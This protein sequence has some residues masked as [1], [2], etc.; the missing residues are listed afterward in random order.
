[1]KIQNIRLSLEKKA[2]ILG[3]ATVTRKS[4]KTF[5]VFDF[6]EKKKSIFAFLKWM[7][8]TCIKRRKT[9]LADSGIVIYRENCSSKNK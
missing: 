8:G 1:M 6:Q 7:K 9:V 2:A 4:R 5:S 3:D